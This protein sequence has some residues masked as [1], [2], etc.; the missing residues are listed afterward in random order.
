MKRARVGL[1]LITIFRFLLQIHFSQSVSSGLKAT[2]T[3]YSQP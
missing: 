1:E 3:A 2:T